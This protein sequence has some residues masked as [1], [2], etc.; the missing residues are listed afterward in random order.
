[1]SRKCTKGIV[2]LI[3]FDSDKD[4]LQLWDG[5]TISK[6]SYT[7]FS[8][9]YKIVFFSPRPDDPIREIKYVL[10]IEDIIRFTTSAS[11]RFS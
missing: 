2:P 1:M 5:I 7:E 4:I 11:T 9:S 6:M 3:Q 8:E 10:K